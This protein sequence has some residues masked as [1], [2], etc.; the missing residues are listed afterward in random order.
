[1]SDLDAD[2]IIGMAHKEAWEGLV[3]EFYV[4]K[5]QELFDLF[6]NTKTTDRDSLLLIKQQH[7]ALTSLK[8][9]FQHFINTGKI[10]SAEIEANKEEND[11]N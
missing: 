7:N 5:E 1:M 8:D 10:A 9:N 2:V 11:D 4:A 6:C 3:S